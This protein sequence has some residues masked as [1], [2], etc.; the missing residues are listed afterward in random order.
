VRLPLL[1]ATAALLAGCGTTVPLAQQPGTTNDALTGGTAAPSYAAGGTTGGAGT[2]GSTGTAATGGTT[3]AVTGGGATGAGGTGI[4]APGGPPV[5]APKASGTV[6]VGFFVVKD[7]GPATRAL[8]VDGLATGNGANQVRA[9]VAL[10]NGRGGLNGRTVQPVIY[11]QDATRNAETQF[12]EACGLFFDDHRVQAVVG[13]GLL[14]AVQQ[15]A[16]QHDVPYVTSGNRTTSSPELA[17]YPNVVVPPQL[18][19]SRVIATLVPSL[20]SQGWFRARTATETVKVGLL[21]N[22]DADYAQVPSLV[23]QQ[24][25]RLGMTLADKQSMAGVDDTSQVGAASSAGSNAV[26]RFSTSGITHVLVVDKSGQALAYFGLAAQN[27]GYYPQLGLSSLSLPASLRTVLSARQLEGARGI[28]WMPSWDTPVAKAPPLTSNGSACVTA[29]KNAG[30]DMA[31]AA[32]RGTALATCDSTLLLGAALQGRQL[33]L[34]GFLAG[35]RALGAGWPPVATFGTDFSSR[36]DGSSRVRTIAFQGA[37][38]CFAYTGP[39]T[40]AAP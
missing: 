19:L 32:T 25:R 4:A 22:E 40:G 37:C 12:Q 35:L 38:D 6:E 30:E 23:E 7:I 33:S 29:L 8:G 31:L 13:W 39:L 11:E 10:L 36:R 28:G 17:K 26:L 15:C 9:S 16:A 18:E 27:Q 20:S 1:A 3:G 2:G 21:Y 14:P 34:S 5:V 24:L